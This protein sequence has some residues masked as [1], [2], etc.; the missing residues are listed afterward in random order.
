MPLPEASYD[1]HHVG[2]ITGARDFSTGEYI[3][4]GDRV[5]AY[6]ARYPEVARVESDGVEVVEIDGTQAPSV[7][8]TPLFAGRVVWS[9]E[10][11]T[12]EVQVSW[13]C[14]AWELHPSHIRLGGMGYVFE[15]ITADQMP[16]N[17]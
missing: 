4:E 1:P 10:E 5:V 7:P 14:P 6:P 8:D 3:R 17:E 15:V 13:V 12:W 2:E 16:E 11:L 9:A